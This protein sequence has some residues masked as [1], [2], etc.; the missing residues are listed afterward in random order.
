MS[1]APSGP[2]QL[3]A[4]PPWLRS[5]GS[6]ASIS[7]E[8]CLGSLT[9]AAMRRAVGLHRGNR[10]AAARALAISLNTLPATSVE[11]PGVRLVARSSA[12][13]SK[14]TVVADN[15][16]RHLIEL[17]LPDD[18]IELVAESFAESARSTMDQA[19]PTPTM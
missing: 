5:G 12:G 14:H 19:A 2:V 15:W 17:G 6:P 11:G 1:P 3:A 8:G 13:A 10:S 4:L 16:S 9:G 18:E 7:A